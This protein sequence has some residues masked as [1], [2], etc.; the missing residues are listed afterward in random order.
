MSV[1]EL[2]SRSRTDAP[3]PPSEDLKTASPDLEGGMAAEGDGSPQPLPG[4][5]EDA[6][7][8]RAVSAAVNAAIGGAATAGAPFRLAKPAPVWLAALGGGLVGAVAGVAGMLALAAINPPL[9]KR[10]GPLSER[11]AA[12]EAKLLR[13]EGAQGVLNNEMA[14]AIEFDKSVTERF[15]TQEEG[16]AALEKRAAELVGERAQAIGLG[17]PY[18]GV[19]AAQLRAAADAGAGFDTELVTLYTLAGDD[20]AV[21]PL[22][23]RLAGMARQG[24]PSVEALRRDLMRLA[25]AAGLPIGDQ[26]YYEL[27]LSAVSQYVGFSG[28]SHEV[29][30]ALN[31]LRMADAM[32]REGDVSGS[33]AS[34]AA[35]DSGVTEALAPWFAAAR[36][37]VSVDEA[38]RELTE[39]NADALRRTMKSDPR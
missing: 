5:P 22:L 8:N 20:P 25:A 36:D 21:L 18:F 19:A 7:G 12:I 4:K 3:N 26:S 16:I 14:Q 30:A 11:M 15:D 17:S 28:R 27:G 33:M 6:A 31:A 9:D 34:L 29:E 1:A 23:E 37:R 2:A 39:L 38:V 10:V 32:L 35:L 13:V 24:V